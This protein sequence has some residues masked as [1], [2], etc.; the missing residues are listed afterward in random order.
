MHPLTN[1][2]LPF[3]ADPNDVNKR[4]ARSLDFYLVQDFPSAIED[5]NQAIIIEDHFFPVYFNRTFIRYKQLEFPKMEKE[6][7][8]KVSA[9]EKGSCE[10]CGL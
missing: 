6:Y 9:G 2:L 5:L 8:L 3:V 7:D 1:R 10:S 4:F